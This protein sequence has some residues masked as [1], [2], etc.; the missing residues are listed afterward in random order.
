M[1]DSILAF[2]PLPKFEIW[3][4][5]SGKRSLLTFTLEATAR[6]NNNC[7]HCYNNLPAGDSEAKRQELTREEINRIAGEAVA[8]GA[9]SCLITGGEPL[10]R[11]DFSGIYLDLKRKGL[12][13]SVFTNATLI[14]EDHIEL[15]K[16]Y[17]PRDI[18]VSVY[19]VTEETYERVTRRRGSFAAFLRGLNLL[20]ENHIK[21]RFKA[22]AL[23]SNL[24]EMPLIAE[25]CRART[26]DYFRFDPF[27][28]LRYDGDPVRNEE[29]RAERLTADEVVDLERAD[30]ERFQQ[31]SS[32]CENLTAPTCKDGL[33]NHL[34]HCG[35]GRHSFTL[36][37]NGTL[38]LCSE[39][40]HPD[41]TYNLRRGSLKQAWEEFIPRVMD[42]R[43]VKEIFLEKCRGCPLVNFCMWCPAT[44]HLETGELDLPVEFFCDL[45]HKRV[46]SLKLTLPNKTTT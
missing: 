15:F 28:S 9:L 42:M 40:W 10:L 37:W 4:K 22:M 35:A 13:V 8:L 36:G 19:G 1:S 3:Y 7:A 29:I 26:K 14:N 45:A 24:H 30:P 39:L 11:E 33:C 16:R 27:L 20:L 2:V 17:P 5:L 18:E 32:E 38:R 25:F 46:N 23:R 44:A 31:L 41:C 43:S 34:F 12:L 21:V 6:C